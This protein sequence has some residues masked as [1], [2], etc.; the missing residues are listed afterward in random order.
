M[1]KILLVALPLVAVMAIAATLDL[2]NL[3][4]YAGQQL[5]NYLTKDNTPLNNAVSDKGATLGRV[6]FYDKRLSKNNTIAC[7][8]CHHQQF[9][10]SD[11][12]SA[13][14]GVNGTTG[15]HA[16]RLINARFADEQRFF[17][18]E[19][20][21]SLEQQTTMPIQ[22]HAEMGFSGQS[23]DPNFSDLITKMNGIWYYPQ[24]FTWVFGDANITEQRMQRALA[25]F[26]RSIQSYDSKFDAGRANA[27][28]DGPPFPNFTQQE[29]Q[30]KQLFLAPPQFDANGIRVAGGAGCAGCHRPPEFDIAPNSRN[31]G[32]IGS[33]AGGND[34]TNTR[35]P[36]LRDVVDANG[37]SYGGFMHNAGQNGLN[38]LIDVINHYDS[39]PQNNPNLDNRLRPGGNLQRLRLTAQE[40]ANIASFIRTLT[41]SSVYTDPRWSNP[42]TN[43]SL[44]I[45]PEPNSVKD[46]IANARLSV[47][48]T[49][50]TGTVHIVVPTE[51]SHTRMILV[52]MSG[53][54]LYSGTI[55]TEMDL[56]SYPSGM[57]VLR[58]ENGQTEKIIK[59]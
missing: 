30:G 59:Q 49:S 29:N 43:D 44:T 14:V 48:P 1:K 10:F 55:K 37:N 8:S 11:T 42:F 13:S 58:F 53:A 22:D 12:A 3:Y 32:V 50:T 54:T 39:I 46:A 52:N 26:V 17:W 6:L 35:S 2:G 34:L 16:M 15:R 38:T 40:K 41:G 9:A 45:I 7:A 47:Y 51:M 57:Y 24:L 56:S 33:F 31:N 28:N 5:P 23:G 25:Q 19:R 4:T 27:P 18:D 21:N 36:S 20:A